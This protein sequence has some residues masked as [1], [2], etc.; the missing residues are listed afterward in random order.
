MFL[1]DIEVLPIEEC[2]TQHKG[3]ARQKSGGEMMM[4]VILLRTSINYRR[5]RNRET[6]VMRSVCKQSKKLRVKQKGKKLETLC[7]GMIRNVIC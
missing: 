3:P 2:I 1:K 7:G 4:L 6:L 5:S